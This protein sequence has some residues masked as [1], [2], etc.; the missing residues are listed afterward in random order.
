MLEDESGRI[1]LVGD[2]VSEERLVTGVIIAAL[3]METPTGDFEVV[4]ICTAGL[5]TFAEEDILGPDSMDVDIKYVHCF[6]D[7]QLS[8][9]RFMT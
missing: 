9:R 8:P 4:D 7:I 5:A 6:P 3:G 2:R 1:K